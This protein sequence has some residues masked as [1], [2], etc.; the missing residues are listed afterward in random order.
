MN[1]SSATYPFF[2]RT[3][4]IWYPWPIVTAALFLVSIGW[5][6]GCYKSPASLDA[7]RLVF[8]QIYCLAFILPPTAVC[9]YCWRSGDNKISIRMTKIAFSLQAVAHFVFH[10]VPLAIFYFGRA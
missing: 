2:V 6:A 1:E 5:S 8:L 4:G 10:I 3:K 9:L 7:F